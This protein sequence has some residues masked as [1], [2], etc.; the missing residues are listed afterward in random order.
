KSFDQIRVWQQQ[1]RITSKQ[2][3]DWETIAQMNDDAFEALLDEWYPSGRQTQPAFWND[4]AFNNPEQPVVG[5]S[6]YEARAYC[7]WL[8]AQSDEPFRLPSEA[9]WEAA[10]RGKT[11]ASK[12]TL[13]RPIILPTI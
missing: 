11:R 6:W 4:D 12:S 1:G 5:I 10:T 9:E 7:A 3:D 2:A 13:F 8:S